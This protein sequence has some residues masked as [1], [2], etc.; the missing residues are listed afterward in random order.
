MS[1]HFQLGQTKCLIL[2]WCDIRKV[3]GKGSLA[4]LCNVVVILLLNRPNFFILIS[5]A[6]LT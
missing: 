2:E 5:V 6:C 3:A 4:Y 1:M